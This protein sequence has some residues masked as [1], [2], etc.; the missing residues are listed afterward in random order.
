MG[1]EEGRA[2]AARG[3]GVAGSCEASTRSVVASCVIEARG[4]PALYASS[5]NSARGASPAARAARA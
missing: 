5:S 3:G 4:K 2:H 1:L